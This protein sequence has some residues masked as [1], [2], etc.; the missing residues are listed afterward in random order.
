[1]HGSVLSIASGNRFPWL[2]NHNPVVDLLHAEIIR[3]VRIEHD[4]GLFGI[5]VECMFSDSVTPLSARFFDKL[6][7]PSLL[8]F[9]WGMIRR[10]DSE[11]MRRVIVNKL[12]ISADQ[13]N[14]A[15]PLV[16]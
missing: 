10:A 5:L 11:M 14:F 3:I 1:M 13:H 16:V 4:A 15:D 8:Q 6:G 2:W 7:E 9:S 12:Q